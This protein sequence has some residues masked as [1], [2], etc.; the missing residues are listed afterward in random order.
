M[1]LMFKVRSWYSE[2]VFIHHE[3]QEAYKIYEPVPIEQLPQ[4]FVQL[5]QVSRATPSPSNIASFFLFNY[6]SNSFFFPSSPCSFLLHKV[7]Y[8][9]VSLYWSLVE[10]IYIYWLEGAKEKHR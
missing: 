4:T 8:H 10:Y 7:V 3:F 6:S 5:V 1:V 9:S 2:E